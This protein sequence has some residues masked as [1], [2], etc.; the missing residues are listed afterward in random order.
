MSRPSYIFRHGVSDPYHNNDWQLQWLVPPTLYMVPRSTTAI[1]QGYNSSTLYM[2]HSAEEVLKCTCVYYHFMI[3]KCCRY[4][5]CSWLCLINNTRKLKQN[6]CHF[7]NNIFKCIFLYEN[8]CNLIII[9]LKCTLGHNELR[10]SQGAQGSGVDDP[11]EP[12]K[13]WVFNITATNTSCTS[14]DWT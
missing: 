3:L 1:S 7:A 2:L 14:A 5:K 11:V 6:G 12:L 10:G 8:C 4:L 9:S 13:I